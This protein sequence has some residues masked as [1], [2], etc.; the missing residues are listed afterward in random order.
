MA[1]SILATPITKPV[2]STVVLCWRLRNTMNTSG[3]ERIGVIIMENIAAVNSPLEPEA[4]SAATMES[5]IFTMKAVLGF[6]KMATR[7][8]PVDT[9]IKY[10]VI[11]RT[12]SERSTVSTHTI[13]SIRSNFVSRRTLRAN[14]YRS[15]IQGASTS[16]KNSATP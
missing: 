9:G 16:S 4:S 12:R 13:A 2:K 14:A 15:P 7:I 3:E 11:V 1:M 6:T 5:M 8:T 10:G